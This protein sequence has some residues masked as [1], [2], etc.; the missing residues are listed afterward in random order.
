[1]HRLLLTLVALTAAAEPAGTS[2]GQWLREAK[3]GMFI[4]WGFSSTG[5]SILSIFSSSLIR[6]CTCLALVA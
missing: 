1:M 2:R 5:N 3:F 4:H 6:L